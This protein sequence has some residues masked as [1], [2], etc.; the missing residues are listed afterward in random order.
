M[1]IRQQRIQAI[2]H[3]RISLVRQTICTVREPKA[4]HSTSRRQLEDAIEQFFQF[5]I[6]TLPQ[7]HVFD[8]QTNDCVRHTSVRS[9]LRNCLQD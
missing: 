8:D 2:G 1:Q 3:Q 6:V 7:G 5:G 9:Y 4:R